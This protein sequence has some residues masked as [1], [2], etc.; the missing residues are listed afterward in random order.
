[1]FFWEQAWLRRHALEVTEEYHETVVLEHKEMNVV[2]LKNGQ[3]AIYPN[4]RLKWIPE[5]LATIK[6]IKTPP[7]WKVASNAIWDKEWLE[8]PY[9]LFGDSDWDY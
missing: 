1:M 7:P 8:Q 6:A 3:I 5:S 4:N 9:E 2:R